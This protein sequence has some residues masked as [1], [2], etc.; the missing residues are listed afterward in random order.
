MG[1]RFLL[2]LALW[3]TLAPPPWN[4]LAPASALALRRGRAS[5]LGL[6]LLSAAVWWPTPAAPTPPP[7]DGGVRLVGR[8]REPPASP[9]RLDTAAGPVV[10]ELAS[11]VDPPRPGE[12]VELLARV[13]GD[14]RVTGVHVRSLGAP[15]GAWL[16]RLAARAD[17]RIDELSHGP[18]RALLR[19]LL[20][21]DRHDLDGAV[22]DAFRGTGTSH[23]LA[24]SGLHVSL[25]AGVAGRVL[26]APLATALLILFAALAGPRAPLLRAL[27]T[28]LLVPL[29]GRRGPP[30]APLARL[31]L[32]ALV[33]AVLQGPGFVQSLSGRLSF[34]AVGGLLAGIATAPR[35]LAWCVGPAG[36]VLAT[37]PLCA[38]VFGEVQPMGLLV[39]PL[40]TPLVAAVLALGSVAVLPG[41]S[42]AA[43][44]PL[45]GP[46]LDSTAGWLLAAVDWAARMAPRPLHPGPP[47]IEPTVL[48]LLIVG[49][50]A[51]LARTGAPAAA[52]TS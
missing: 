41:P 39:T 13:A 11:G 4:G 37:A 30:A 17:R 7:R 6:V 38:S 5:L 43:L 44:D 27:G 2:P 19:S 51:A 9:A 29:W 8:W 32:V 48:G 24:L 45:L 46:A 3:A 14:G 23:L 1:S 35:W 21:G 49:A 31:G 50:L 20:L 40:L 42:F 10:L 34:L 22:R 12:H 18:Q 26:A 52:S 33:L 28:R 15:D 47:P 25:L 36:A 16:D